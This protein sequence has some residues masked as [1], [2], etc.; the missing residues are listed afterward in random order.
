MSLS[1]YDKIAEA[2]LKAFKSFNL[3]KSGFLSART[4]I[5]NTVERIDIFEIRNDFCPNLSKPRSLINFSSSF[6]I[7]PSEEKINL[8][9]SLPIL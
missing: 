6:V 7:F 9:N 5:P 3:Y 4:I 2:A 1:T 8:F